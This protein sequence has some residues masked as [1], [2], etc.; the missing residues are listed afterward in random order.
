M[1]YMTKEQQA[2]IEAMK[3]YV[4]LETKGLLEIIRLQSLVIEKAV[5]QRDGLIDINGV[6]TAEYFISTEKQ[7]NQELRDI[8]EGK[9]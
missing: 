5:E 2:L 6:L 4:S 9:G 8:M 7:Y 3:K 1:T